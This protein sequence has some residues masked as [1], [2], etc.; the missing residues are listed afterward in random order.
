MCRGD[1]SFSFDE[2]YSPNFQALHQNYN[3]RVTGVKVFPVDRVCYNDLVGDYKCI[4]SRVVS[5]ET[6]AWFLRILMS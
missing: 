4:I 6:F 5:C 1:A 2:T 3:Q